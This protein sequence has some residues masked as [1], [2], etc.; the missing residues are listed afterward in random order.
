MERVSLQKKE[1]DHLIQCGALDG[2]GNSRSALLAEAELIRQAGSARQMAFTFATPE[3]DEETP[4]ER[5]AWEQHI[6]G[7]PVSV[8]PLDLVKDELGKITPLAVL[9]KSRSR[10]VTVAGVRLPGW[11]GGP[12]FF[13]GDQESF[14]VARGDRSLKSPEPWIP[15]RLRGRWQRDEWGTGW[16]QITS[17]GDL[18]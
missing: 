4:A 16:F 2:L 3:V 7:R 9:S 18:S 1:V 15:L 12:G 14:V 8:H 17:L 6:L 11:T 5:L 10:L 13:L